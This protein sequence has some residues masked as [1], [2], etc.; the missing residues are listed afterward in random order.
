MYFFHRFKLIH[1][2]KTVLAVF[3]IFNLVLI[4][5]EINYAIVTIAVV[6]GI[7]NIQVSPLVHIVH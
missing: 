3:V 7:G 1:T 5:V 2:W 6:V 4:S